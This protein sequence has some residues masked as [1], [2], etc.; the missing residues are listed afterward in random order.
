MPSTPSEIW[1]LA[2]FDAAQ[3]ILHLSCGNGA[4]TIDTCPEVWLNGERLRLSGS[5]G[6][7]SRDAGPGETAV[8]TGRFPRMGVRWDV[9]VALSDDAETLLLSSVIVNE[10]CEPVVLGRCSLVCVQ[11]EDGRV[12]LRGGEEDLVFLESTGTTG[13]AQVRRA[14]D[15]D[16]LGRAATIMHMVSAGAGRALHCGFVSYDTTTTFHLLGYQAG[17][18]ITQ[19][20]CVSDFEGFALQPGD[21]IASETLMLESRTDTHASLHHWADRV[22]ARH[23]PHFPAETPAGWL[24]WSWV[25]AFNSERCEDVVMRNVRA[26]RDRLP[27]CDIGYVWVSIANIDRGLPGNWL[28]WDFSNFPSGHEWLV[29]Q[30]G[31]LGFKLGFWCGAFWV[32]SSLTDLC[33]EMRDAMLTLNGEPVIGCPEWRYGEAGNL[34]RAQRPC[35]YSLDPTHPKTRDFLTRVF[36]TYRDWGVG[37]YMVDFLN[38]VAGSTEGMRYDGYYD[39]SLVKG[40][41]VLRAG[42][43]TIRKAAGPDTYLLSSSGP[44]F[45]N[46]GFVDACRVGNDYGE[47]RAIA[48]ESYF[49][50]ATFVINSADFWTSH[51]HAS[52]NMAGTYFTHRKLYIN[53][54]GNVMTVDKPIPLCEAQI[55]ATIFG[56]CGGPV[57]LGDDIDRIAEERLALIRKVFP[58]CPQVARPVD[59]FDRPAPDYPRVFHQHIVADWD[60]WEV[61]GVLNYGSE[62]L[63]L[64][65]DLAALGLP[66][67]GEFR[68]WEFWNEQYLQT[69]S[70]G[71]IAQ[72]PPRSA[73]LYR[74]REVLP[75]PWVLSTDMHTQQGQFELS[76]VVW[77][78]DTMT[79]SGTASRPAGECGNV[80]IIAPPGLQVADPRGLWIAKDASSSCLIIGVRL[81]FEGEPL[82]WQVGFKSI[83]GADEDG[84]SDT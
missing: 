47:G 35:M 63:S 11:P 31:A 59:L 45:Q 2:R 80:F 39:R 9:Q 40:P 34:P 51:R 48:P 78:D 28:E 6:L 60:E 69:V 77:N 36:T 37:Y 56:L 55:T 82:D 62:P 19:L 42:L 21:S 41:Q 46:V 57:M 66:E 22:A 24:G 14:C 32:A 12:S 52:D 75:H 73:R 26:I 5:E 29:D 50:P 76:D 49:F 7:E 79:L 27:G 61:V 15:I 16:G 25:D 43:E 10:C 84:R 44:T 8:I 38:A 13:H 74:I 3:G 18:G 20:E 65:V 83:R 81:R 4:V 71:F 1:D 54:A 23:R 17:S 72:V 53:D 30:L 64:P 68:L 58:R 33:A 67:N 70:S